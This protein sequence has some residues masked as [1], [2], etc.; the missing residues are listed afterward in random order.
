MVYLLETLFINIVSYSLLFSTLVV[1]IMFCDYV[2]RI[3][4][5]LRAHVFKVF[6][7]Y[8][9]GSGCSKSYAFAFNGNLKVK[10]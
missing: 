7:Q 5:Q 9:R 2:R 10:S 3:Y 4:P 6:S 8:N 1:V